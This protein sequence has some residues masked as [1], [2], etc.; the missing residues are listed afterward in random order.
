MYLP[1]P[2]IV[3]VQTG[4]RRQCS[5]GPGDKVSSWSACR[6]ADPRGSHYVTGSFVRK[7]TSYNL[8]RNKGTK[9]KIKNSKK[10]Q[11][12]VRHPTQYDATT[13]NFRTPNST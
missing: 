13:T 8:K 12:Y 4:V 3:Q 10:Q 7:T 2:C 5:V 9:K 1:D 6:R 11:R